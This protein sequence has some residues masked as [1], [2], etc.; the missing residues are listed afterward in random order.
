SRITQA[1]LLLLH[2]QLKVLQKQPLMTLSEVSDLLRAVCE[3]LNEMTTDLAQAWR[4]SKPGQAAPSWKLELIAL[5]ELEAIGWDFQANR[6]QMLNTGS[7]FFASLQ[8]FC[9]G[10]QHSSY[11]R[12][13]AVGQVSKALT[14]MQG[15]FA[16]M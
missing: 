2:D 11:A 3:E 16:T 6:V 10:S 7:S 4:R 13:P 15:R 5:Q 14:G 12:P 1:A 8:L 9:S